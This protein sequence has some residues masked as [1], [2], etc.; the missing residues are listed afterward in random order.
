[1]RCPKCGTESNSWAEYC[2]N[3]GTSLSPTC[4]SCGA[5]LEVGMRFCSQCG[6]RITFNHDIES[7]PE[8]KPQI[9]SLRNPPRIQD[10]AYERRMVTVLFADIVGFSTF[11]EQIDPE[12]L[13][14]IMQGV[15]PCLLEP[16]QGYAGTVV[17]VMGDGVLA[18]FG[19]PIAKEDDPQRA[20]MAALEMVKRV[21]G[22]AAQIPPERGLGN[23][24]VRVGI[25]TGLV[26]VGDMHPEKH[27][28]Y[29]ALGDAV[30]LAFRL[31][32][33]APPGGVLVSQATYRHVHG[34][35]DESKGSPAKWAN[36]PGAV[37]EACAFSIA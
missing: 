1:M 4:P 22:Y 28:E 18:Y 25:N 13:L 36:L 21:E 11:S 3:C 29:I 34:L 30:I 10:E 35:F 8:E 32:Q 20:I 12:H 27:L 7:T 17:Q 26:V 2:S 5:V 33:N 6:N 19:A 24:N 9:S 37:A 31:Q 16:I 14:E 23:F 15:Y